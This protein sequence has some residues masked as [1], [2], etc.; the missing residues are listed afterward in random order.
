MKEKFSK[1]SRLL[2][3]SQGQNDVWVTKE[4]AEQ[5]I[6]REY[7]RENPEVH[8]A[9]ICFKKENSEYFVLLGQRAKGRKLFPGLYEGCGGQLA[10][11]ELFHE[12]VTRHYQKEYHIEVTVHKGI[13]SLYEININNEPKIPGIRFLC[14]YKSGE[15]S[16]LNHI[17]PTPKWFSERE[18][19][20]L[21]KEQFIP[22]LKNEIAKFFI[23]YRK[24]S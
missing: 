7:L 5:F 13:F 4:I 21:P 8:V 24:L 14:E 22:G 11:N 17:P 10:G 1:Q 12:G 9:G 6:P 15:P 2:R 18:F 19:K 20:K 16:S 23:E 3:G